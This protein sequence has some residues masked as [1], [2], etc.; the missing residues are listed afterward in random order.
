MTRKRTGTITKEEALKRFHEYYNEKYNKP[1]SRLRAKMF[2]MMYEKKP[3]FTL[4]PGEPGSAKY[5]LEEGPKTFDMVGVDSFPE[6]TNID[7]ESDDYNVSIVSKGATYY[8]KS[9]NDPDSN[10]GESDKDGRRKSKDIYGPRKKDGKLYSEHFKEEYDDKHA[11]T[12]KHIVEKYWEDFR[13]GLHTRKNKKEYMER[14]KNNFKKFS[15]NDEVYYISRELEIYDK[16]YENIGDFMSDSE[17]T[18]Y[19]QNDIK[20]I[21][22]DENENWHA[23]YGLWDTFKHPMSSEFIEEELL[24]VY[25][26]SVPEKSIIRFQNDTVV[27]DGLLSSFLEHNDIELQ[28]F[29]L[30]KKIG[31]QYNGFVFMA[32]SLVSPD[33]QLEQRGDLMKDYCFDC[34]TNNMDCDTGE[35]GSCDYCQDSPDTPIVKSPKEHPKKASVLD[36]CSNCMARNVD[37]SHPECGKCEYCKELPMYKEF[38]EN[39]SREEIKNAYCRMC[40]LRDKFDCGYGKCSECDHCN[41]LQVIDTNIKTDSPDVQSPLVSDEDEQ[42]S[43]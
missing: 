9:R 14:V 12:G 30:H 37:C 17:M 29:L 20:Y 1:I 22:M 5:L 2:D 19:L 10:L 25:L 39:K 41:Q 42:F 16:D 28:E 24:K 3:K 38:M 33:S 26:D 4:Y 32:D 31:G 34:E 18:L 15:F 43:L 8:D 36:I 13:A 40:R 35:C 21:T 7:V 11:S 6:G 23:T 27:G